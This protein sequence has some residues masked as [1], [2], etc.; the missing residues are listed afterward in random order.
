MKHEKAYLHITLLAAL[1]TALLSVGC[2]TSRP[3]QPEPLSGHE[4]QVFLSKSKYP[5][6][7]GIEMIDRADGVFFRKAN[8]IK[9]ARRMITDF[10]APRSSALP[11]I[12]VDGKKGAE[13]KMLIDTSSR[14]SWISRKLL[15]DFDFVPLGPSPHRFMA[16]HVRD[17][18]AGVLVATPLLKINKTLISSAIMY[19]R[20][21]HA[22]LW[23]V[24]RSYKSP[25]VE[26][27]MG[28]GM[29]KAFAFIRLDYQRRL[30]MFSADNVYP[31]DESTLLAAVPIV[32]E[33]GA[34]AV[35]ALID[36]QK[37]RLLIDTGGD[38]ELVRPNGDTNACSQIF[39]EDMVI[40]DPSVADSRPLGIDIRNFP[41]IGSRL[42]SK[43]AIVI[44]MA[45]Q[46]IIFERP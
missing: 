24:S 7:L 4:L 23:P 43:Y 31:R 39:I 3:P 45:R 29:M 36:G 14:K 6:L 46:E 33:E 13:R 25:E 10:A 9:G 18:I 8:E 37:E 32:W 16:T 11:V 2:S 34:I 22:G 38:Y 20:A 5:D 27:V 30:A 44:D 12:E 1:T 21:D 42:L 40:L 26:A 19:M 17:S 28:C 41:S 15:D 35:E